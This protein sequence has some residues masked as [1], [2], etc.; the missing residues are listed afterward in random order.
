[1]HVSSRIM[2]PGYKASR[3]AV[4][5]SNSMVCMQFSYIDGEANI[6][7]DFVVHSGVQCC[8]HQGTN[9]AWS[10]IA[11]Y[12]ALQPLGTRVRTK[13]YEACN[14]GMKHSNEVMMLVG[15]RCSISF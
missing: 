9:I 6:L 13:I 5:G 14:S 10:L 3:Q 12:Y 7:A 15:S 1:M 2:V 8:L 11:W 4:L